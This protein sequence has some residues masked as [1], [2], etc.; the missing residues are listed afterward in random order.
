MQTLCA[1]TQKELVVYL[2]MG[3]GNPYGDPWNEEIVYEWAASLAKLG[4]K[5]WNLQLS[6]HY[7]EQRWQQQAF[8]ASYVSRANAVW[9]TAIGGEYF[10]T[11]SFSVLGGASTAGRTGLP[12]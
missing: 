7:D 10:I 11:P 1:A 2:S 8:D 3:F 4:V 6:A 5:I 9:N 12:V